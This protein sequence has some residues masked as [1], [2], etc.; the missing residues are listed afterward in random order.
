MANEEQNAPDITEE[1]TD[2]L[3]APDSQESGDWTPDDL[4]EEQRQQYERGVA[5]VD[6]FLSDER[7]KQYEPTDANR[8]K[9]LAF[10]EQHDLPMSFGGLYVAFEQL[11]ESGELELNSGEENQPD[12][13]QDSDQID[14]SIKLATAQLARG[15]KGVESEEAEESEPEPEEPKSARGKPVV[16]WRNG[17]AVIGV[18]S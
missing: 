7:T 6:E 9:L 5:A 16:A 17:R 3:G 13:E 4:N 18:G 8:A 1:S 14:P 11:S 12:E 2:Q 10:L 15:T